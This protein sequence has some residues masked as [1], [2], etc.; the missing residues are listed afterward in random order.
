MNEVDF[1]QLAVEYLQSIQ[2]ETGVWLD[3]HFTG[4]SI[5]EAYHIEVSPAVSAIMRTEIA[6]GTRVDAGT[7]VRFDLKELKDV[8]PPVPGD[9]LFVTFMVTSLSEPDGQTLAFALHL[10]RLQ[11]GEEATLLAAHTFKPEAVL[12]EAYSV[13]VYALSTTGEMRLAVTRV[14]IGLEA[15]GELAAY[16][17]VGLGAPGRLGQQASPPSD[18]LMFLLFLSLSAF[19]MVNQGEAALEQ[20]GERKASIG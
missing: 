7:K 11:P 9:N 19:M 1:Q 4:H 2:A 3:Q 6:L 15:S 5:A 18:Q 8:R 20:S 10:T 12:E 16:H 17:V 13:I 14:L